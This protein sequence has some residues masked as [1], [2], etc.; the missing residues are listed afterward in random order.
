MTSDQRQ[1]ELSH[2]ESCRA[3]SELSHQVSGESPAKPL[4]PGWSDS[5]TLG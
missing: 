5:V 2:Q 1:A 4:G 3:Q